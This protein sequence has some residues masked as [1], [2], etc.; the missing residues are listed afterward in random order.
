MAAA[1]RRTEHR[2]VRVVTIDDGERLEVRGAVEDRFHHFRVWADVSRPERR[3]ERCGIDAVRFPYS[4]CPA[5]GERVGLL[6]GA[7][8][9]G[10]MSEYFRDLDPRQQCTHQLDVLALALALGARGVRRRRYDIRVELDGGRAVGQLDQDGAPRLVLMLDGTA[11]TS[12]AA[13][14]GRGI[15][16]GFT[17]FVASLPADEADA[18]LVLRRM[19]FVAQASAANDRLDQ[20]A[21]APVTGGC[22]VQQRANAPL[23]WRLKGQTLPVDVEPRRLT[24]DDDA[25]LFA[26][27]GGALR[28]PDSRGVFPDGEKNR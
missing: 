15:G 16:S 2:V 8:L 9:H 17:S 6:T 5:A 11:I 7:A 26:G 19:L 13:Y 4:G 3:V 12:P 18:A 24:T 28:A 23:M 27:V 21:H 25:F 20:M 14:A 22:W 10:R 1:P